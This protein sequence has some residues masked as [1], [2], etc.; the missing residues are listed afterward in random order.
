MQKSDA[1][2]RITSQIN[3]ASRGLAR[4]NLDHSHCYIDSD[5]LME[6]KN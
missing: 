6:W 5:K 2:D 4:G 3:L 1:K